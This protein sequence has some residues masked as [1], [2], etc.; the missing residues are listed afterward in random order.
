MGAGSMGSVSPT[1]TAPPSALTAQGWA[2]GAERGA[3]PG[4]TANP[5][6]TPP[7][8][9]RGRRARRLGAGEWGQ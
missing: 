2:G 1:P 3:A 7:S 6:G 5:A 8:P 9:G 4:A